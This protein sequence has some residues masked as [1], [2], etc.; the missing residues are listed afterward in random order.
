MPVSGPKG[1]GRLYL[2]AHKQAGLWQLD[3][4]KFGPEDSEERADLLTKNGTLPRK[5]Q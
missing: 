1:E 3:L 5:N 4:L 2:E